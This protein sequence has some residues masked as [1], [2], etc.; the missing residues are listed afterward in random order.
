M[1]RLLGG[2]RK[3]FFSRLV[4]YIIGMLIAALLI[5]FLGPLLGIGD[6]VPLSG[7][8]QRALAISLMPALWGLGATF[9]NLRDR[10][11][12]NALAQGMTQAAPQAAASA[13]AEEI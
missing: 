7:E 13:G 1:K 4:L 6:A 5:W 9:S 3:I 2:L 8:L 10:Q 12:G 11:A